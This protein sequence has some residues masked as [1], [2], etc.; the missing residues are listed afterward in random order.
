MFTFD[1]VGPKTTDRTPVGFDDRPY[2]RFGLAPLTPTIGA[3]VSGVDLGDD[4][5]DELLGE[6]RRALLEWKVL[7]FRDQDLDRDRH[8]AVAESWGTLER[9]PFFEYVHPGQDDAHVVRLAK[10]AAAG[11][12]ENEWHADLTW[13][14]RP[15]FGAVL[16]A[17]EVPE[18]GGDTLWA[19]AGA[20]YDG[21]PGDVRERIDDMV[22][23]HDWR[24]TFGLAMP[25]QDMA[26][27]HEQFPPVEHP[28]VRVHPETGRRT[29]FVNPFFTDHVVGLSPRE[30]S[31]LLRRLYRQFTRPEFQCRFRWTPGAVAFWDNRS[32]QHYASSDYAP[33]RRVMDR[34]SIA[35]D[36]PF[37]C[38]AASPL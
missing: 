27:L 1:H 30:S 8:R 17:V 9:H 38:A 7:F 19:D 34:I 13:H 24:D 29:L 3:E 32:C 6:L 22:A 35:G 31:D 15:S 18:L 23:V 5:D 2:L 26:A 21:L 4:L 14:E 20:A 10:D 36:R 16:R 37:G 28:V 11:G 12:A 25:P 33:Q